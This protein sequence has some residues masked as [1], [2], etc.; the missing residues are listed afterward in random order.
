[1]QVGPWSDASPWQQNW[2]GGAFSFALEKVQV[3]GTELMKLTLK[4]GSVKEY[5]NPI[6]AA[7]A[8]KDKFSRLVLGCLRKM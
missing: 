5:Q 1:M 4:D 3:G 8:A 6:T 7:E 2:Q